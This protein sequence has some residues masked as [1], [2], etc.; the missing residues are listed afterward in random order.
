MWL[1][2]ASLLT[3]CHVA[4]TDFKARYVHILT[5]V[6]LL[7]VTV[8]RLVWND[9]WYLWEYY[10]LNL[11]FI[12]LILLVSIGVVA[13]KKAIQWHQVMGIG[14]L[15]FL[16]MI[17]FWFDTMTF[18][19]Y[20]NAS[21]VVAMIAHFLLRRITAYRAEEGVPFAGYFALVLMIFTVFK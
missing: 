17:C 12:A 11:I 2:T 3:L 10:V 19:I 8:A 15:L 5:V 20:F 1:Q 13:R 6:A 16:F 9:T 14:D 4:F 7:A 21:V 18:V